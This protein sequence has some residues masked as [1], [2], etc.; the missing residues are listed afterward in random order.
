MRGEDYVKWLKKAKCF[1]TEI[2]LPLILDVIGA[3]QEG[4]TGVWCKV[5]LYF[6]SIKRSYS[7]HRIMLVITHTTTSSLTCLTLN[8][9]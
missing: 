7:S 8:L 5:C 3:C 6:T 9:N 2:T 1:S 4:P